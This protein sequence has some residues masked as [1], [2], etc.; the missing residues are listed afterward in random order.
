MRSGPYAALGSDPTK[1]AGIE[2]PRGTMRRVL[3][4]ARPYRARIAGF[5]AT[6]I[7]GA[8]L[9]LL[10][11]L[12]FRQIIDDVLPSKDRSQLN[13]LAVAVVGVALASAVLSFSERWWSARIGEGLI[14][15]LRVRLFDHVQRMP[16]AFFT[17][18]QTGALI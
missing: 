7:L 3:Q 13:V 15:D 8:L 17:R 11:P 12:L 10:P 2:L 18:T 14:Y 16:L 1:I 6:I 5:L 9:A 4:L